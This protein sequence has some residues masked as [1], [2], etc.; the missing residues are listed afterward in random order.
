MF[1]DLAAQPV[2]RIRPRVGALS[3]KV[4]DDRTKRLDGMPVDFDRKYILLESRRTSDIGSEI[5]FVVRGLLKGRGEQWRRRPNLPQRQRDQCAVDPAA[6]ENAEGYIAH[7][8]TLDDRRQKGAELIQRVVEAHDLT[9]PART[10]ESMLARA[11]GGE[12]HVSSGTNL[13][14]ILDEGRARTRKAGRK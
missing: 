8:L 10:P 5:G 11:V 9:G 2:E 1:L 4:V 6:L 13:P 3:V 14:D 7:Q 12:R